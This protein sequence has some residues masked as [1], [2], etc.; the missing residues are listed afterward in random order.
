[1]NRQ[2]LFDHIFLEYNVE[3][4]YPFPGDEKSCVFRHRDNRKWFALVMS[5][6][7]RTLGI[8]RE[9]N[10]DILNL[11]CDPLLIGSFRVK[12]GFLPA[13]HMNKDNWITIL[14]DNVPRKEEIEGILAMSFELTGGKN[15]RHG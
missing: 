13:Y 1:M 9:G 6:P 8:V 2:E 4:D 14:L 10:I 3:P 12:S 11:K 15:L 5:V 7:C